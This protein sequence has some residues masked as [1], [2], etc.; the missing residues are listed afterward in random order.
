MDIF[1]RGVRVGLT[2]TKN[3]IFKKLKSARETGNWKR[4]AR[5]LKKTSFGRIFESYF[6]LPNH[7]SNN[8]VIMDSDFILTER[9]CAITVC[10]EP[11]EYDTGSFRHLFGFQ[12]Q[13]SFNQVARAGMN[14]INRTTCRTLGRIV[15]SQRLDQSS[16]SAERTPR[17]IVPTGTTHGGTTQKSCVVD[18][19]KSLT[20][21]NP[22]V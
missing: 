2:H 6:D 8:V 21:R 11:E 16:S 17:A 13:E 19:R 5:T 18:I 15:P 4:R 10:S 12:F 3:L 1:V 14:E 20:V 7:Y 9:T 22:F